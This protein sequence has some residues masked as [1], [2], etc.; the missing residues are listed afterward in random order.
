[1]LALVALLVQSVLL[2]FF[3]TLPDPLGLSMSEMF[4][5]KTLW[6]IFMAFGGILAMAG[7][8]GFARAPRA[9]AIYYGLYFF[10]AIVD[11]DVF[12][13]SHQRLSYSFLRTYFHIS[14]ITDATTVST[15]GGDLLGTILWISM[16]VL[17]FVGAIAFVVAYTLR[18]R[19]LRRTKITARVL[20]NLSLEKF[21]GLCSLS[22]WRC[23]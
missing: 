23:R 9:L 5:G 2:E 12:R 11:Y 22:A 17:C 4:E 14:N 21:P 20:G 18:L 7:L 15:L 3:Y 8:F 13:F 16:V 1:M 6:Q 10:V 19:K